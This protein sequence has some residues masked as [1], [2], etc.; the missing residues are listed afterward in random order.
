MKILPIPLAK[1]GVGNPI[2][3]GDGGRMQNGQGKEG[4]LLPPAHSFAMTVVQ[5]PN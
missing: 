5:R 1:R 4:F 3:P 2:F